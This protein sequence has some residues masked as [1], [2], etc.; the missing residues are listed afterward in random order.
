MNSQG[1]HC[2]DSY[3][4]CC[5]ARKSGPTQ[6]KQNTTATSTIAK[7]STISNS[8]VKIVVPTVQPLPTAVERNATEKPK[9]RCRCK[10]REKCQQEHTDYSFGFHCSYDKVRCCEPATDESET[11]TTTTNITSTGR[12][13]NVVTNPET[14][15]LKNNCRC[16]PEARCN[17][18]AARI[19]KNKDTVCPDNLI[20]CCG[21]LILAA[22]E[23]K[24]DDG[25]LDEDDDDEEA[26]MEKS[27]KGFSIP[28]KPELKG[29]LQEGQCLN[30]H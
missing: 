13:I 3:H 14:E 30:S 1:N 18:P 29:A 21:E 12:L 26:I 7:N 22:A 23:K 24:S 27:S 9:V 17:I 20:Q 11:T 16:L 4:F 8:R 2:P 6:E 5:V 19:N 28:P 25:F 15:K 10:L